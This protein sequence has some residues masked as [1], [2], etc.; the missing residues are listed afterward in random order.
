MS[1]SRLGYK[2]TIDEV[3]S[4]RTPS[5]S[6]ASPNGGK[7]AYTVRSVNW[8][9][10]KYENHCYIHDRETGETFQLTKTGSVTDFNWMDD[11][12]LAVLKTGEKKTQVYLYEGL[13][14]EGL[15]LTDHESGVQSFK[16]YADG[17]LYMADD[18]VRKNRKKRK[19]KYGVFSRYDQET[20]APQD[21]VLTITAGMIE[22]LREVQM[23]ERPKAKPRPKSKKKLRASRA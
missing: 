15:Q 13:I 10:N 19:D 7:V 14:G 6:K 5:T 17:I 3:H 4:L 16:P 1:D 12:S 22:D 2:P 8:A 18:P 11:R 9:D 20:S 21:Q 23:A